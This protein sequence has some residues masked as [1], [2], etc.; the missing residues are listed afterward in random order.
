MIPRV[1][2]DLAARFEA[3]RLS[4]KILTLS[5]FTTLAPLIFLTVL[6]DHAN[7]DNGRQ[8]LR[9]TLQQ[10]SSGQASEIEDR[11]QVWQ[12]TGLEVGQS[13]AIVEYFR[14]GQQDA[15]LGLLNRGLR[16]D[17]DFRAIDV[18][19]AGGQILLSTDPASYTNAALSPARL[20]QWAPL[21]TVGVSDPIAGQGLP[22]TSLAYAPII[23]DG[24]P[25]GRV[26][27]AADASRMA[28]FSNPTRLGSDRFGMLI[29]GNGV[30]IGYNGPNPERVLYHVVG[31]GVAPAR[32][33]STGLYGAEPLDPLAMDGFPGQA[34]SAPDRGVGQYRFPPLDRA[35]EVGYTALQSRPWRVAVMQD[36]AVFL[37]PLHASTFTTVLYFLAAAIPIGL[38]LYMVVRFLERTERQ[39]L[40]DDLTGL[41]NRRFF[42]DLLEREFRRA[43]RAH[44][45][46]SIINLDL[47]RFK[48][49]NDEHGHAVGDEVL[50]SF[51][52]LLSR[53]VRSIDLPVRYGGEEFV[54]L[55]P[56]TDKD[57]A[58]QAAEK[59]R[60]AVEDL[61]LG[62][63]AVG[64]QRGGMEGGLTV[65]GGIASYP[66][67]GESPG[68]ILQRADQ[69]MYLA[70]SLGRNQVVA[71]G[72]PKPLSRLEADFERL[73]AVIR[74][75]N[76]ATVE[77]L[78]AAID[79]RD[80]HTNGHSRR[81]AE[82]S[83]LIAHEMEL[84]TNEAD[85][86]GLAA[87][88]HDVGRIATNEGLVR[89]HGSL[90]TEERQ[91]MESH[92]TIGH[93]MVNNV[94]FLQPVAPVILHHHENFDGSGYPTG[95]AGEQIPLAARIIK[96]ADAFE[97][98]TTPRTYR[99]A[100]PVEWAL[101]ELR[102]QSGTQFDPAVVQALIAVHG[103]H[104]LRPAVARTAAAS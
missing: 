60:R 22:A 39:S 55:L 21:G 88:L 41:P 47:D 11:M 12:R 57:G 6:F 104:R 72:S 99:D 36:E 53:H 93:R 90:T 26:V 68:T 45:P 100:R 82:F 73:D 65:S 44:K 40:H 10:Q 83:D 103:R 17:P 81:V 20:Q 49:I 94:P 80:D 86:L 58:T 14:T 4:T 69:A 51:A 89:K 19:D 16:L 15:A 84:T 38:L 13:P 42:H 25:V 87:L 91:E 27:I 30:V 7:T 70:K 67:D 28:G 62:R 63:R 52:G 18:V 74:N 75:A 34:G 33:R 35:V 50:R 77:A 37:A 66:D 98:M 56:D 97:A 96:V 31:A 79:A 32:L 46:L 29:D 95:I 48:V 78:S 76:R 64:E 71:F 2:R 9:T 61:R 92:T 85:V 3:S 102:R 23:D 59:I 24:R 43:E 1:V 101:G 54:V 8:L 5:M